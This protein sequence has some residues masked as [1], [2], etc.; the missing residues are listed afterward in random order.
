M[1]ALSKKAV[2]FLFALM[3]ALGLVMVPSKNVRA[4]GEQG[5]TITNSDDEMSAEDESAQKK[6]AATTEES[7]EDYSDEDYGE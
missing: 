2:N 5:T 4:A 6:K 1:N 7:D 3:F